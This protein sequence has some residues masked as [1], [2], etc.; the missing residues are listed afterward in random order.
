MENNQL[1]KLLELPAKVIHNL[2]KYGST[3]K[4]MFNIKAEDL[5][6][7]TSLVNRLHKLITE[8][9]GQ[10]DDGMKILW[11][12]LNIAV[13]S[14]DEYQKREIPVGI[15]TDT[16]KFCTRFLKEYYKIYSCYHF[17]WGWWF[18]R[19]L[20]LMEF[21]IGALEYEFYDG[22]YINIH[23]P[24]DADL[25]KGSVLKSVSQFKDFCR[26][27]YP[28]WETKQIQC[29]S[30]MLSPALKDL[31]KENSNI[32]KFQELF[33]ITETDYESMAVL[34]WVFP[35]YNKVSEEL[36]ENTSLQANMKKYL[37][38]GNNPGWTKGIL[39]TV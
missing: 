32:L 25:T 7:D 2:D 31:L 16:M 29:E 23:I 37:L 12:E 10:D 26:Q 13:Q 9:T 27:Y 22:K 3:R 14:F 35:G 24:S 19:Q 36:P 15:F 17:I 33:E 1:Y 5:I 8:S 34:D 6:R 38:N 21:R 11:E 39:K 30:W 20:A 28:G 18:P 4:S